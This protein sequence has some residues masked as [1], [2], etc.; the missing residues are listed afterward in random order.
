MGW[1]E[2]KVLK[3]KAAIDA[4]AG[5][6]RGETVADGWREAG[7]DPVKLAGWTAR[8]M[9]RL[10]RLV[11]DAAGR[12]EIMLDRSCVFTEEFGDERILALRKIY[13]D[14][15]NVETVLQAMRQDRERF[16]QPFLEDGSIIEIRQPR[17]KEAYAKA[18][19][20][21]ERQMSACFCPLSRA[22][23]TRLPLEYCCCS[24]GWYRGIYQGI[25][26]K[27]AEVTVEKSLLNGDGS[28]R[29]SIKFRDG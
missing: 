20:D 25:F 24:A 12:R 14:T 26:Q 3:W 11:P 23:R 5:A 10:E 8:A 13:K 16:G 27:R 6:G 4:R 18:T 29:F 7:D 9:E 21:Y 28:C 2:E 17:D 19:N 15:G 22:S 1:L